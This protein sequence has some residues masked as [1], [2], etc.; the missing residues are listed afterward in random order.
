LEGK[1]LILLTRAGVAL[2]SLV[3]CVQLLAQDG[4]SQILRLEAF[5]RQI[6][7]GANPCFSIE[8]QNQKAQILR[9]ITRSSDLIPFTGDRLLSS[10]ILALENASFM[11]RHPYQLPSQDFP[12]TMKEWSGWWH[13]RYSRESDYRASWLRF[14]NESLAAHQAIEIFLNRMASAAPHELKLV[15]E[16]WDRGSGLIS[17]LLRDQQ[18]AKTLGLDSR[19]VEIRD[20][21]EKIEAN[22]RGSF[23]DVM[24]TLFPNVEFKIL[25]PMQDN[26]LT[27]ANGFKVSQ[28]TNPYFLKKLSN[29]KKALKNLNGLVQS[30]NDLEIG[31]VGLRNFNSFTNP[32]VSAEFELVIQGFLDNV[33]NTGRNVAAVLG[34]YLLTSTAAAATSAKLIQLGVPGVANMAME[35]HDFDFTQKIWS[36]SY[37]TDHLESALDELR[38]D[39]EERWFSL[40]RVRQILVSKISELKMSEGDNPL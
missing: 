24:E 30:F 19:A 10:R 31:K 6:D 28:V 20:Q 21:R 7:E 12:S 25:V 13:R 4:Q 1:F 15:D 33:D 8:C 27:F 37:R 40:L 34:F 36:K 3:C 11:L 17:R 29:L 14:Q 18:L 32:A 16:A 39:S 35:Y 26:L 23:R 5:L 22:F 9:E 38:A 2:A